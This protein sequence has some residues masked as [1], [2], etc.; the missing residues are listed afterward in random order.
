M[1]KTPLSKIQNTKID[2]IFIPFANL[3]KNEI[4]NIKNFK[5]Y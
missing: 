5:K 1:K 3:E 4:L 2:E